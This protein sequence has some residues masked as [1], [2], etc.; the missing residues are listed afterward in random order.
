M[1]VLFLLRTM[2][3]KFDREQEGIN[4]TVGD[5]AVVDVYLNC[6]KAPSI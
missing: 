3:K 2:I 6:P 5:V 1:S 4:D